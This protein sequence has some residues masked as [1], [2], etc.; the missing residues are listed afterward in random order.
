MHAAGGGTLRA[1]FAVYDVRDICR[2][3]GGN[4]WVA[5]PPPPHENR[6]EGLKTAFPATSGDA[7]QPAASHLPYRLPHLP[8]DTHTALHNEGN[9]H[10]RKDPEARAADS[11]LTRACR[12]RC[13]RLLRHT[14]QHT[15]LPYTEGSRHRR[16][17]TAASPQRETIHTPHADRQATHAQRRTMTLCRTACPP[18]LP[19]YYR[20]TGKLT[21]TSP[22]PF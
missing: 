5:T 17:K 4:H 3:T 10:H 21:Y 16:A 8:D 1:S 2:Q 15:L 12:R 7:V 11:T 19:R 18:R 9:R 20:N 6:S 22:P 14:Y 13:A